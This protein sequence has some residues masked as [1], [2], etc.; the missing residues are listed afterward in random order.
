[1]DRG[2][3]TDETVSIE[4]PVQPERA[5]PSKRLSIRELLKP[6][7]GALSLGL[8]GVIGEGVAN[9]LE[10]WPLKIVLDDVLHSRESHAAVMRWVHHVV[11]TDKRA[12]LKSACAAVLVIAVLNAICTYAEK[13]LTISVGQWIAYDLRGTIYARS[14]TVAGTS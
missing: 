10:P 5:R 7:W 1:L 4:R 13:D 14:E 6:H 12:M 8:F 11:G 2:S 9:L 3:T